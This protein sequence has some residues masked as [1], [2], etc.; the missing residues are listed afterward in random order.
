MID[1]ELHDL[2][3]RQGRSWIERTADLEGWPEDLRMN[4]LAELACA[5]GPALDALVELRRAH[6]WGLLN[7]RGLVPAYGGVSDPRRHG[8]LP[9]TPPPARKRGI[10]RALRPHANLSTKGQGELFGESS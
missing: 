4:A 5:S 9:D 2:R 10:A 8:T 7:S 1:T 6:L 3:Q